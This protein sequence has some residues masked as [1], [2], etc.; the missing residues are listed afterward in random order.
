ME[1]KTGQ[2]A[3]TFQQDEFELNY[4]LYLPPE[5]GQNPEKE[6]PLIYFLHGI[7][8]RGNT[9][10][11]LELLKQVGPSMLV[12][13]QSDFPFIVLS[14]QCPNYTRWSVEIDQLDA[15]LSDII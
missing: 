12:E 11:D 5:Y 4:L 6:W 8:K 3:Y 7:G 14:P 10:D 15:L 13:E 1:Y 9:L 2:H